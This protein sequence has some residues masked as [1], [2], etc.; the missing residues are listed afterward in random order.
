MPQISTSRRIFSGVGANIFDKAVVSVTQ[1]LIVAIFSSNW[2]LEIY[3]LWV[4]IAT[5][6]QFLSMGDLGFATAAG[7]KMTME[8]ARGNTDQVI[9]TFHS[10][11]V[12][13][14]V[15]SSFLIILSIIVS[16]IIPTKWLS[17]AEGVT[18][19]NLRLLVLSLLL[20]GIAIIQG[21]IFFAAFKCDGKFALGAFWNA[22]IILIESSAAIG[23]VL[24]GGGPAMAAGALLIGRLAG[25]FGQNILLRRYV[26][27]LAIGFTHATWAEVRS[28]VRPALAVMVLP[29]AQAFTLQ[30]SAIMLGLAAGQAAVPSFTAARTL[31]RIGLQACW[32]LNSALLPEASA[33]IA[34][35]DRRAVAMM[36]FAT[37]AVSAFLVIPFAFLFGLIGPSGV[38]IW[39]NGVIQSSPSMMAIMAISII[40]GGFWFPLSNFLLAGNRHVSYSGIFCALS[41]FSLP[42]TYLL[43]D[44]FGSAGAACGMAALDSIMLVT[45]LVLVRRLLVTPKEIMNAAP[46]ALNQVR[47]LIIRKKKKGDTL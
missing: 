39:T 41:A 27:W 10:A 9:A 15:S 30:G 26:P 21:T 28:L 32:L 2:G 46:V 47:A 23:V 6:P 20:Y 4:L 8:R 40:A 5:I 45:I 37:I 33:A 35:G 11:C 43:C 19:L 24:L 36:V 16:I 3:G 18:E 38:S 1:L 25:L 44:R 22:M 42:I 34:K 13:I 29:L 17:L 14:L 7:V 12:A 31:S